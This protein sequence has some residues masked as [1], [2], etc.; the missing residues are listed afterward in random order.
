MNFI[1][2]LRSSLTALAMLVFQPVNAADFELMPKQVSEHVWYFQGEPGMAS[3]INKGFMSN[4]GFVVT[5]DQIVVFDAL[6]SVPLGE[7]MVRAIKKISQLPIKLVVISHYHADHFYGLQVFQELG[8]EVWAH[9]NSKNYLNSSLAQA[10]LV[11][12]QQDLF[13]Y[14]DD[15]TR[16]VGPDKVLALGT[17]FKRGGVDFEVV[18][19]HGSHAD[20]D[21]MLLVK[22][23]QVLF[24]GDLFFSGRIPFVG[25][26]NTGHWLMALEKMLD[27][28]P[29]IVVPGHGRAS[30]NPVPD[31][32]MTRDYLLYLRDQMGRAVAEMQTFDE[33]YAATDWSKY[34]NMP[35]FESANRLNAN[36]VFT[37]LE[38]SSLAGKQ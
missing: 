35:A 5:K 26:A 25:D 10:R 33:A 14:V 29:H 36:G 16:L 1:T 19:V 27:S 23:D 22:P 7:A 18:D 37:D 38:S 28:K 12:R 30:E 9:Q 2:L 15:S 8:A 21:I 13:P 31:I 4:A 6:G 34:R 11:Q 24:A 32:E 20:D 17:R 3:S